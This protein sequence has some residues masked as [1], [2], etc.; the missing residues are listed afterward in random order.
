MTG[1]MTFTAPDGTSQAVE[2]TVPVGASGPTKTMQN[3]VSALGNGTVIAWPGGTGQF[4]AWA[5]A[6]NGATVTLQLQVPD[7]SNT[8]NAL[9]AETTI[10]ANGTALFTCRAGNLRAVVSGVIPTTLSATATPVYS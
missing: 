9:G 8:W 7:G 4:E 5:A 6:W 3:A 10:A 2:G 1:K